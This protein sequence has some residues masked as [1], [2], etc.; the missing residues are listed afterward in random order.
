[1][2]HAGGGVPDTA[3]GV[4]AF[5]AE[6]DRQLRALADRIDPSRLH[7]DPGGGEWTLAENLAHI[8]EFPAWFANDLVAQ[9]REERPVVGR[10]HD[11]PDRL[12]AIAAA[13]DRSLDDLR[14][15]LD[16]SLDRLTAVL[17][18]LRDEHIDKLA[19]NR[20]YGPE[21]LRTFL[22]RYVLGHKAAHVDQLRRTI[23][24]VQR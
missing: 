4:R 22:D 13:A 7:D 5:N 2:S 21:P 15:E 19:Q 20:K 11:H 10:T 17:E 24:A 16:A 8:A 18:E 14:A 23:E 3:D 12:A 9:M 6:L 1:V